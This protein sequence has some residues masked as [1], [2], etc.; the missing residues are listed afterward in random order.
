M[1]KVRVKVLNA[2]VDGKGE[3]ETLSIDERS[4]KHL[5]SIGY[6]RIEAEAKPKESANKDSDEKGESAPKKSV[7]KKRTTR[8][9]QSEDNK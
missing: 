8:K 3:G 5:E 2:V 1:A 6:V 7:S 9:K 4:A